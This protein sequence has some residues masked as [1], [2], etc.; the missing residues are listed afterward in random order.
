MARDPIFTT[1]MKKATFMIPRYSRIFSLSFAAVALIAASPVVAPE[2]LA[3]VP[4][5]IR[6][7]A[8]FR[9]E[10]TMVVTSSPTIHEMMAVKILSVSRTGYSARIMY[11]RPGHPPVV[12]EIVADG[13]GWLYPGRTERPHDF[14]TVDAARYCQLPAELATGSQWRCKARTVWQY[15]PSGSARV[16]ATNV[17]KDT[18]Q[19]RETGVGLPK[20]QTVI[21]DDTGQPVSTRTTTSWQA[22]SDFS[23]FLLRYERM[24]IRIDLHVGHQ[25][26]PTTII[27]TIQR[28]Q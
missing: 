18:L 12:K 23:D 4:S 25:I 22:V 13:A 27:T 11:R 10:R 17:T 20:L 21:D 28:E 7:G 3:V 9:Y 14:L 6:P 19:L 5:A 15:W 8:I 1:I 24:T 16:T 2:S 26:L